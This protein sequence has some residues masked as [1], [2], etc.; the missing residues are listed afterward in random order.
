MSTMCCSVRVQVSYSQAS[1]SA[2]RLSSVNVVVSVT[3]GVTGQRLAKQPLKVQWAQA[4]TCHLRTSPLSLQGAT[5][6]SSVGMAYSLPAPPPAHLGPHVVEDGQQ[7]RVEDAQPELGREGGAVELED[8]K[9]H[10][11]RAV[12]AKAGLWAGGQGGVVSIRPRFG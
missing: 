12:P 11:Q 6:A 1:T 3:W 5:C 9:Q 8:V 10:L 7:H 2:R 4:M